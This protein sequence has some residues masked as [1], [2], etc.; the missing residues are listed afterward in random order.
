MEGHINRS[1]QGGL[2]AVSSQQMSKAK[3]QATRSTRTPHNQPPNRR[4]S[5]GGPGPTHDLNPFPTQKKV[6][7]AHSMGSSRVGYYAVGVKKSSS[8]VA[9]REKEFEDA[10][11]IAGTSMQ[12]STLVLPP[13]TIRPRPPSPACETRPRHELLL[14]KTLLGQPPRSDNCCRRRVVRSN[15]QKATTTDYHNDTA[16]IQQQER[17]VQQ[18]GWQNAVKSKN[19]FNKSL[20]LGR[21]FSLG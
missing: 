13:S 15:S 8:V 16:S 18:E 7:R 11:M 21:R 19:P 6:K 12:G 20:K 5:M 17:R 2:K 10:W 1:E 9:R 14:S 3:Q 4:S